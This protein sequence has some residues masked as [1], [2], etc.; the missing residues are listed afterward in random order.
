VR[1]P[2]SEARI[3]RSR[4][5]AKRSRPALVGRRSPSAGSAGARANSGECLLGK[6]TGL[7]YGK[8]HPGLNE[9]GYFV[10]RKVILGR[11]PRASH[12]TPSRTNRVAPKL[13][14]PTSAVPAA[15]PAFNTKGQAPHARRGRTERAIR[16]DPL[17]R[18]SR[19]RLEHFRVVQGIE[20]HRVGL[21]ERATQP[22][23]HSE[24][25]PRRCHPQPKPELRCRWCGGCRSSSHPCHHR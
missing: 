19:P 11:R 6:A 9:A 14:S 5:D 17:P 2:S 15:I 1:G 18:A 13:K 22:R 3:P 4:V 21:T 23:S 25:C 16:I 12:L 24:Q 8:A 10:L 20:N 7:P